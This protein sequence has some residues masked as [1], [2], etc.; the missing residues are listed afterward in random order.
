MH[1]LTSSGESL[2]LPSLSSLEYAFLYCGVHSFLPMLPL[3]SPPFSPDATLSH[4]DSLPTHDVVIWTD[5]F[6]LFFSFLT[7]AV[8]AT[9]S[10]PPFFLLSQS[11]WQILQEV[12]CLSSCTIRLQWVP[13]HSFLPLN[14]AIDKVAR[15]RDHKDWSFFHLLWSLSS[16]LSYPLFYFLVLEAY[17]P[18]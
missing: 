4:L 6:D 16:Y 7:L 2:W 11:L 15:L 8:L 18:I 17:C 12:S 3:Q 9:V 14:D 1:P 10:S 13:G 5:C